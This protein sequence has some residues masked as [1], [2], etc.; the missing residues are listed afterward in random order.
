ML[1]NF[2]SLQCFTFLKFIVKHVLFVNS[3]MKVSIHVSWSLR[4][5]Y[6]LLNRSMF[7]DDLGKKRPVDV[8][9]VI[10]NI[11]CMKWDSTDIL[12]ELFLVKVFIT[13]VICCWLLGP[14]SGALD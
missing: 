1:Y 5:Y 12:I 10:E 3:S 2:P 9:C 7:I 8:V 14:G 6:L 11:G 4:F 13:T